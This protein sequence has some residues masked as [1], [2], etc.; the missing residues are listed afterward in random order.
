[1]T[2]VTVIYTA[3]FY[4]AMLLFVLGV[5]RKIF[6][7]ARTP[8]PLKIPITP[9]PT[10]KAGVWVRMAREVVLFESLFKASKWTWLFG[11]IFHLSLLLAF[12]RHLRYALSPESFLWPLVNLELVQTAGK[13]GGYAMLLGL[14]GLLARRIFVDRV[15]YISSPSDFLMLILLMAIAGSGLMM[16]FISHTDIVAL[17]AFTLGLFYFDPQPLPASLFLLVH[18]GLVALLLIIFPFSKLLHAPGLFFSPTRNQVDNPREQRWTRG[19]TAE[20][21]DT[22]KPG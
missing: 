4:A 13:Y 18:L 3:L 6:I 5:G 14:L 19:W 22:P 10:T 15:R 20:N 9:A 2:T 12:F 7:Y 1:M 17:K 21:T 11:W 8:Q 16:T